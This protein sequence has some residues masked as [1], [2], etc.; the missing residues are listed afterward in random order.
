LHDPA[1]LKMRGSRLIRQA[2]F[3]S[4]KCHGGAAAGVAATSQRA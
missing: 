1:I 4:G 2:S 3:R